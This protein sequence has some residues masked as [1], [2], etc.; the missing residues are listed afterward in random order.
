MRLSPRIIATTAV[1]VLLMPTLLL[2]AAGAEK[3]STNSNSAVD[4]SASFTAE[5]AASAP[6]YSQQ[7]AMPYSD[8]MNIGTP[9]VEWFMGYSYLRAVPTL[10]DGN[11]MVWLNG[12]STSIAFNLNRYFGLVGDFGGFRDSEVRLSGTGGN[13]SRV[14]DSSGSAYNYLLGPRISFRNHTR[15]TPFVQALFGGMYASEVTSSNCSSAGCTLLPSENKFAMTAGG[16]LDIGVH[17]H[18]AIR[19][20][21]AEYLMT[22]FANI[23]TGAAARQNDIRL[24]AGVVFRFGGR[25]A[26]PL[27]ELGSVTYSCSVNPPAVFSGETTEASGTALNLNPAKTAVYTWSVDGGTVVGVS[28]TAKIDTT[29]LAVGTYTLKGHVSEGDKPSEN[30]DCTAP[31]AVKANVPPTVSCSAS[32]S[33]VLSGDVSTITATGVSPDNRPL[34]YSYSAA[35]GSI[36]GTGTTAVFSTTGAP[37][38][39]VDVTCNVVD[40]KGQTASQPTTVTITAPPAAPKPT[41]S[42]LCSIRFERDVRRPSRVDNEAKACLDQVALNLQQSADAKLAIVGNASTEEKDGKKIASERAV[43]TK[44]WL[45]SEKGIDSSRIAVYT[46]SLNEMTVSSTLIPSGATFSAT[47]DTPVNESVLKAHPATPARHNRK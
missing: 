25:G 12:G 46:G 23:D 28:S 29:N 1:A 17:P 40:D 45:V 20:V 32:P 9:R 11:R 43:N 16:G 34:A 21:Q 42:D 10:A 44:A 36:S 15:V 41:T 14:V 3:P 26:P 37:L 18:F 39:P 5:P 35:S 2:R 22:K 31:Y 13:A 33:T 27:P 6:E 19:I 38:G 47:G 30:A 7:T 8:G 24:S 4:S